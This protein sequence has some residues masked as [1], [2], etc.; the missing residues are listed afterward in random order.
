MFPIEWSNVIPINQLQ[1]GD[2]AYLLDYD[3]KKAI[4][5][6][7][8][9]HTLMTFLD[10]PDGGVIN[11]Q[12]FD[13]NALVIRDWEIEFDENEV[14]KFEL[15]K[16][17]TGSLT[18]LDGEIGMICVRGQGRGYVRLPIRTLSAKGAATQY[19][20]PSWR[21]VK[22]NRDKEIELHVRTSAAST[23]R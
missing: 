8:D 19:A 6:N 12:N 20:F 13:G 18:V 1:P 23:P 7:L 17:R 3:R 15:L 22:R 2:F 14:E 9:G 10:E 4:V 5:G 21:L 16:V 11:V